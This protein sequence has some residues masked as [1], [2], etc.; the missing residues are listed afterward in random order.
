MSVPRWIPVLLPLLLF[1]AGCS[2]SIVID[3]GP[4]GPLTDLITEVREDG[5][6][7]SWS[8][9]RETTPTAA[10]LVR[11]P[12]DG[13]SGAPEPGRDY[14]PGDSLGSGVAVF[15]GDGEETLD[16][17]AC[18]EHVYAGWT[19]DAAG[20]W[21]RTSEAV[22][23]TGFVAAIPHAPADLVPTLEGPEM[24]LTWST[25]DS[26]SAQTFRLVRKEGVAP[27]GPT[28]GTEVYAGAPVG[29]S[30]RPELS[31]DRTVHYGVYACT[32]CG[33]CEPTG[34]HAEF[35]PTLIQALQTGGF[36]V[37]W[38][39]ASASIC[40]DR[41]D[42]GIASDNPAIPD[43][44]KSCSSDCPPEG[45]ATARQLSPSGVQEAEEIGRVLKEREIPFARMFVSEYCRCQ[46]TA[47]LLGVGA[48]EP[49]PEVTFFVYRDVF[50]DRCAAAR[51]VLS[52]VPQP[53]T[54][55]GVVAHLFSECADPANG[56]LALDLDSGEGAIFKPDGKGGVRLIDRLTWD[57]WAG[58]P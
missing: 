57:E 25:A 44:W 51:N 46:Q 37:Y 24:R 28:D 12:A 43:W 50:P 38:R 31:P 39:H 7:L 52:Q 35:T 21:S 47:Q 30:D 27:M 13:V 53:G 41:Q 58:L 49:T 11:F 56:G 3:G 23:M 55:N 19:R 29:V 15:Y 32:P 42:L 45:D 8:I 34:S 26:R 54:N 18:T 6:L 5:V 36:V 48:V 33:E 2:D 14:A 22:R 20:N 40:Q 17:P 10:L 4:P 9:P 16:V 1:S